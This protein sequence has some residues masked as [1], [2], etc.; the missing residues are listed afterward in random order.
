MVNNMYENMDKIINCIDEGNYFIVTSH[1]NPDGDNI[2]STLS[3]YYYLKSINKEVY[4]VL[5]DDTPINLKFL[6]KDIEILSSE[7]FIKLN[8]NGFNLIS[9]DCG[10]LDRICIDKTLIENSKKLI[11]IDHHASNDNYGDINYVVPEA[12]STCELVYNLFKRINETQNTQ[13]IDKKIATALYTGVVT[14]TGK[15]TYSNTHPSTFDM[16]KDLLI[17]GAETNKVI[18]EVSG[19]NPYN[20]YKLLGEALNTLDI[21]DTKIAVITLTQDMLTRNNISFKDT[22]GITPYCRDIENVEV[23]ILVKEKSSNEIKISLRSKNYVDVSHIA[24]VFNGGGHV[25]AAGL[26][27][28]NETIENATKMVVA[29]TLKYI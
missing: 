14:D 29:E 16:A 23:G 6:L 1:V 20:Y 8:L 4:Y 11:C 26:T 22:D 25:R 15:F 2:G 3:M 27:V 5:D 24:K 18:C 7:E 13:V 10:D 9:L 21:I 19:N 17:L 12:S 28:F